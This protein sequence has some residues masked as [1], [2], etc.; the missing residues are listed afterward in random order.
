MPFQ[1]G[2]EKSPYFISVLK[3]DLKY[4]KGFF[5]QNSVPYYINGGTTVGEYVILKSVEHLTAEEKDGLSVINLSETGK[6]AK[7]NEIYK[8]AYNYMR[9]KYG[10]FTD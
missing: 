6:L 9:Q 8:Y 5:S 1:G 7:S 10:T 3:E 2:F 4:W